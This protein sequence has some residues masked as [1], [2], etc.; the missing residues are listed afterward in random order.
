MNSNNKSNIDVWSTYSNEE[1]LAFG[2]EGDISR[3]E[4]LNPILLELIGDT[5]QKKIL[6]AGCGTGYLSRMLAKKGAIVTG[7]EPAESL[8]KYCS[9]REKKDQ[10]GIKYI[11]QDL[12]EFTSS[13]EF[14]VVISNMVLMDISDYEIAF[15]NCITSLK[16]GGSFV[17]SITH[18]CFPG[19]DSEFF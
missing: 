11:Q 3:K 16:P 6:D 12:S 5:N 1:I 15:R 4:L 9:D 19:S 2:E 10:L 14:D 17:F 7:L 13:E 8:Y 18:P